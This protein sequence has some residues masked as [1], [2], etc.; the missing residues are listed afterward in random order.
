[1][2]K[3]KR[4]QTSDGPTNA[5]IYEPLQQWQLRLLEL[6]PGDRDDP[7][8]GD[9]L[10][11]DFLDTG[12]GAVLH[13]RQQHVTY[14]AISYA[15][16]AGEFT[17]SIALGGQSLSITASLAG[18]LK[19]F[20]RQDSTRLL[21][22]DAIC[23]DQG[24]DSEKS[25][26]VTKI[27][28]IFERAELVRI[29]LGEEGEFTSFAL[30]YVQVQN[31]LKAQVGIGA[32]AGSSI[33]P[34]E[35]SGKDALAWTRYWNEKT[36]VLR[37]MQDLLTR[38]WLR[39]VWVQ[40][41]IYAARVARVHCGDQ[42][43]SVDRYHCIG[44]ELRASTTGRTE[45]LD[46]PWY[47]ALDQLWHMYNIPRDQKRRTTFEKED[48]KP[49][50]CHCR[51]VTLGWRPSKSSNQSTKPECFLHACTGLE[52][53][54]DRDRI[55]AL[56]GMSTCRTVGATDAAATGPKVALH[57]RGRETS[58]RSSPILTVDYTKSV[59]EVFQDFT[60]YII[61]R[62]GNLD[63]LKAQVPHSATECEICLPNWC[64]DWRVFT[65][66]APPNLPRGVNSDPW[67]DRDRYGKRKLDLT[68]PHLYTRHGALGLSGF[69]LATVTASSTD[70]TVSSTSARIP[71]S[72]RE[73]LPILIESTSLDEMMSAL[74]GTQSAIGGFSRLAWDCSDDKDTA[75]DDMSSY[76]L[77]QTK[78]TMID[79]SLL[80][81]LLID[82]VLV[83]MVGSRFPMILRPLSDDRYAFIGS[84]SYAQGSMKFCMDND[85]FWQFYPP[86][87]GDRNKLLAFS[88]PV[89][90]SGSPSRGERSFPDLSMKMFV[91]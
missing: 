63:I 80:S 42:E 57:D 25:D 71:C 29:W 82:D 47:D 50:E 2:S 30:S 61:S 14:E 68:F 54:D 66:H 19:Q 86:K 62:D 17:S 10:V 20:R 27:L 40:Q 37:G 26:Q 73:I 45:G 3:R 33:F 12:N 24:N 32:N 46:Q 9:L 8:T 44:I 11:S 38:P 77:G 51:P 22:A 31:F 1:M 81:K 76:R 60:R 35:P 36:R 79:I 4:D 6:H 67:Y 43:F 41:E 72:A 18:A 34:K 65:G 55:Y 89:S 70:P 88:P 84:A 87:H 23:I 69:R 74:Q 91:Y 83:Q 5:A 58:N 53:S 39:R 64:P 49:G 56:L 48:Y 13:D 52:A 75:A 90:P 16:G 21:W 7:L 28:T 15:W 59:S 85:D 78:C